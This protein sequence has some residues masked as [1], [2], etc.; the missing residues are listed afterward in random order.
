MLQVLFQGMDIFTIVHD[1][2]HFFHLKDH[3]K[4][5]EI[6]IYCIK[7]KQRKGS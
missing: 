5:K 7:Y 6:Q 2:L 3:P 1:S 4:D